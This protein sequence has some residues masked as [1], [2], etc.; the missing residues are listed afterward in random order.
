MPNES[1]AA[2]M[3]RDIG[4]VAGGDDAVHMAVRVVRAAHAALRLGD[5]RC[6][7]SVAHLPAPSLL[8]RAM[9]RHARGL[10]AA[11]GV[12]VRTSGL[13]P[14]SDR[15][16]LLVANHVSWLDTYALNAMS[17]ARFVAKSEV[18][19]W[20]V[21]GAMAGRYGTIFHR[22]GCPRDAWRS[23]A[24]ASRALALGYPV[25]VFPEGTTTRGDELLP[26]HPAFFQAAINAGTPVQP[27]A[28]RYRLARGAPT[29]AAAY[30]GDMSLVESVRRVLECRGLIVE[31]NFAPRLEPA[32]DR[33]ALAAAARSAIFRLLWPGAADAVGRRLRARP[34]PRID[35][36]L[37][38]SA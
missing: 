8:A 29:I 28:I 21:I 1:F 31:L 20:P 34:R 23:V 33:R 5:Q 24:T 12:E 32:A 19:R 6:D 4:V 13:V 25:G 36:E 7:G 37:R 2:A 9:R 16:L 22:R 26:F 10:L 11:L 38:F 18:G 27:V 14:A 35:E 15:P 3:P 17:G 30:C